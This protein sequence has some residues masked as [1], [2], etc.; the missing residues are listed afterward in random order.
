VQ[1]GAN[2]L[3]IATALNAGFFAIF[4]S[5]EG[6]SRQL[7]RVPILVHVIVIAAHLSGRF[8]WRSP[9]QYLEEVSLAISAIMI[10]T[11]IAIYARRE[12]SPELER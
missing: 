8:S 2:V 11:A 4:I 9:H 5:L 1:N 3:L 12:L 6:P 7:Y 10:V